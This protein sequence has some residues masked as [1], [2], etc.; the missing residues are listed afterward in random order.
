[1]VTPYAALR[2]GRP[3]LAA[4]L[5]ELLIGEYPTPDDFEWLARTHGV[6]AIV[7]LQDEYDLAKKNLRAADLAAG[8]HAHGV[9]F[10]HLP[11]T[12]GDFDSLTAQLPTLVALLGHL[13]DGG[14]RIYLHC[15]AGTNRAPTVAIAYL[16]AAR[17]FTLDE[18]E[19]HVKTRRACVPYTD[20]LREHFAGPRG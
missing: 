19:R 15:N 16:H 1:M 13:M 2:V 20:V 5:P 7:N 8:C 18:A 12:D 6:T 9:A 14:A 10:H 4:V 3:G 11:V 17:G